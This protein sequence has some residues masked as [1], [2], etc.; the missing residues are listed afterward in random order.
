MSEILVLS[1]GV[2]PVILDARARFLR[3][4]G[5]GVVSAS[6]IK[7]AFQ[8]FQDGNFSLILLCHTLPAQDCECLAR[9]IRGSDIPVAF[10]YGSLGKH[11]A[12]S[13]ATAKRIEVILSFSA[14]H[15]RQEVAPF[16]GQRRL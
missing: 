11:P 1:V 6:S 14:D 3:S 13:G 5:F 4:A 12:H 16:W 7:E 2:D 15:S 8:V 9:L 10:I